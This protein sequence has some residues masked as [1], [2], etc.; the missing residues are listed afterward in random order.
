MSWDTWSE[1]PPTDAQ[2][3]YLINLCDKLHLDYEE[4]EPTSMSEASLLIDQLIE[5][6]K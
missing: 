5:E 1:L 2:I 3:E 6:S 4:I